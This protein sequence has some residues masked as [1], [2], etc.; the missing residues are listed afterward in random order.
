MP[1][2]KS[3]QDNDWY[4]NRRTISKKASSVPADTFPSWP[5]QRSTVKSLL[6]WHPQKNSSKSPFFARKWCSAMLFC[7]AILVIKWHQIPESW[8][9][10]WDDAVIHTWIRPSSHLLW[11]KKLS[12]MSLVASTLLDLHYFV[13]QVARCSAWSSEATYPSQVLGWFQLEYWFK[14]KAS[15]WIGNGSFTWPDGV[16]LW[17]HTQV[18]SENPS[19]RVLLRVNLPQ[20]CRNN[21][22]KHHFQLLWG[23]KVNRASTILLSS[24]SSWL[25]NLSQF[26]AV[27]KECQKHIKPVLHLINY[28]L[29]P[30]TIQ[31]LK[32]K[33]Q[34]RKIEN[35]FLLSYN[36]SFM[37]T[38]RIF[39]LK[40]AAF[41]LFIFSYGF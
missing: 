15:Y 2:L 24:T 26:P 1:Q 12:F 34:N 20:T 8:Q 11:Y 36:I 29:S 22:W 39:T 37:H 21:T 32:S 19:F 30:N 16:V 31:F 35:V 13:T 40:S 9:F 14:I 4:E 38:I 10:P 41:P 25:N 18:S 28:V 3:S 23:F 33:T 27:C 7:T 5:K 6:I 17:N